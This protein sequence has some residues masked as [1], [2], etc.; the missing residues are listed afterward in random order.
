LPTV[1]ADAMAK[2]GSKST[3]PELSFAD[4][5]ERVAQRIQQ[6][7]VLDE[8]AIRSECPEHA[9]RLCKMLPAL[10]FLADLSEWGAVSGGDPPPDIAPAT[11]AE[12]RRGVVG[13][14]R[15]L[16]EIGC[17]GMGVVYEAEQISLRRRV[18]LKILPFA[19]MLDSR[20]LVR[21]QNESHAAASLAHPNIVQLSTINLRHDRGHYCAIAGLGSQAAE[22]L[23]HAHQMGII[24][25]DIKPLNLLIDGAG[26]PWVTDFGLVITQTGGNL[27]VSGDVLGTPRYMSP[28]QAA[29]DGH[30][31]D[32]RTDIVDD[33]PI[34]ARRPNLIAR[35]AKWSRRN[36]PIVLAVAV[37]LLLV[38]VA[39]P[40][41]AVNQAHLR[42]IAEDHARREAEARLETERERNRAEA[43]LAMALRA[44]DGMYTELAK[45]YL[46][47][48]PQAGL[49]RLLSCIA[50][51]LRRA[52]NER[53]ARQNGLA[54][55]FVDAAQ[56]SDPSEDRASGLGGCV[57]HVP[58]RAAL[59]RRGGLG[60]LFCVR[61]RG[62]MARGAGNAR[63]S[64]WPR[65]FRG[66]R[67]M[68]RTLIEQR[69][70]CLM[71]A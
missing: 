37:V 4:L 50:L 70:P 46:T 65:V 10:E 38:A 20:K 54:G 13:D 14:F 7:E 22:A 45:R 8:E 26:H 15:I 42:Q 3:D 28:E 30:V 43:N 48:T 32:H 6:G 27:T 52:S 59:W 55:L 36:R 69:S 39:S 71:S 51:S 21:F 23:E 57:G 5:L 47:K 63:I 61:Q 17:G 34:A 18:A 24:H 40:P 56:L 16:R 29:G 33:K 19:S 67:V 31:L 11:A 53:L 60:L 64:L 58:G 62:A 41:V 66:H 68:K 2:T 44:V 49:F 12:N 9:E 35:L 1:G 25:R